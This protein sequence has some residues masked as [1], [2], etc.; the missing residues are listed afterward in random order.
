MSKTK[1]L[2]FTTEGL[3][4]D[5]D[6]R[7][8]NEKIECVTNFK[9][10]GVYLDSSLCFENHYSVVMSKLLQSQFIIRKLSLVLPG[11]CLRTLYF[12]YFHSNLTYCIN[13]WYPLLRKACRNSLYLLQKRTV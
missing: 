12:A 11:S 9:F 1:A 6:L 2:L 10:L 7:L 8:N 5:V 13:V 3:M 4:L